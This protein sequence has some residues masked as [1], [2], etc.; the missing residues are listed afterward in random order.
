MGDLK[1]PWHFARPELAKA[2]L[3]SFDLWLTAARGS[4]A[5]RRMG[6]SEFFFN[7]AVMAT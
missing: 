3:T 4:F 2:Y 6:K 5:R 7:D 1:D